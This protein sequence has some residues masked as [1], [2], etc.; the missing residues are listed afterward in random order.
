MGAS[1]RSWH[2]QECEEGKGWALVV[3]DLPGQEL[4]Q[5]AG[6]GSEENP[7]FGRFA[8]CKKKLSA[9]QP[10]FRVLDL[11]VQWPR[12]RREGSRRFRLGL[13]LVCTTGSLA[14]LSCWLSDVGE[15][16]MSGKSP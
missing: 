14:R 12:W 6:L 11:A 10:P 16:G 3:G 9:T 15:K 4:G 7:T 13:F 8:A 2:A 5:N 1:S